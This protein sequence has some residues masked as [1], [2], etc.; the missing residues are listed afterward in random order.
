MIT[1]QQLETFLDLKRLRQDENQFQ[2][3]PL[4]VESELLNKIRKGD[5][6]NIHIA[7]FD[8]MDDNLGSMAESQKTGYVY[9]TVTAIA[10]FSRAVIDCGVTPDEAFDLSD[11]LLY[12]LSSCKT[13][14]EIHDMFQLTATMFAKRVAKLHEPPC[15][16]QV[17]Q[18]LNYIGRNIFQK[19]TLDELS[20]Y[21]GLTATYLCHLFSREVGI[22]IH[23]YIQREKITVACNLLE[24]TTQSI[25]EISTYLG[26]Q[27]QSNFSAIFRK[28]KLMTPSQYRKRMYREVY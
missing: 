12:H 25:S 9:V 8:K 27:S 19:I 15:S 16:Y 11:A 2:R 21:T 20:D 26:F 6:E 22:S 18:A 3:I 13:V 14:E 10:L 17:E 24:H 1:E 7:P 28:W 5:Y 4:E 23:N